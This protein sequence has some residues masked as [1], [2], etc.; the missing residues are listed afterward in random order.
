MEEHAQDIKKERNFMSQAEEAQAHAL[1]IQNMM[2]VNIAIV[3]S[4]QRKVDYPSLPVISAK[5]IQNK[6]YLGK[7][8]AERREYLERQS[9]TIATALESIKAQSGSEMV[10]IIKSL[11]DLFLEDLSMLKDIRKTVKTARDALDFTKATEVIQ[12]RLFH[13]HAL[14]STPLAAQAIPVVSTSAG[15]SALAGGIADESAA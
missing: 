15:Q 11:H 6:S 13:F 14:R 9:E 5:M 2:P 10:V 12:K 3:L 4:E 8:H 7:W 1:Y